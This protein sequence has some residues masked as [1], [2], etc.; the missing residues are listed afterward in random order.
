MQKRIPC[1]LEDTENDRRK[2]LGVLRKQQEQEIREND[3]FN[4]EKV[5]IVVADFRDRLRR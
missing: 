3:F 1:E 4:L 2:L 5:N